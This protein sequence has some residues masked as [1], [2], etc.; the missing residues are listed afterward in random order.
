[1]NEISSG[2]RIKEIDANNGY[3]YV[4]ILEAENEIKPINQ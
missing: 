4:S 2:E 3:E 1:M